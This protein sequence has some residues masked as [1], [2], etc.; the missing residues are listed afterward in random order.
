MTL[1]RY[2]F[3]DIIALTMEYE[4]TSIDPTNYTKAMP[5]ADY[6][7]LKISMKEEYDFSMKKEKR[8]P[9]GE[10]TLSLLKRKC[11]YIDRP[12]E[13]HVIDPREFVFQR[14]RSALQSNWGRG[15]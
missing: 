4:K 14:P 5:N 13:C 2:D 1:K 12:I 15:W 9:Q 6:E 8:A 3:V 10:I 7:R 11:I